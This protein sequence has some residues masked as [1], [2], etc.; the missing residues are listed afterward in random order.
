M[1]LVSGGAWMVIDV[2][3]GG[4]AGGTIG[5]TFP[6]PNPPPTAPN[7]EDAASTRPRRMLLSPVFITIGC[8]GPALRLQLSQLLLVGFSELV[9][10]QIA[11]TRIDVAD[12]TTEPITIQIPVSQS[13]GHR[14]ERPFLA[15]V[16]LPLQPL[17]IEPRSIDE[18][19][20]RMP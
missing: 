1:T 11:K 19:A 20:F 5:G 10:E 9:A 17:G 6:H 13:R 4:R 15:P 7:Y 2:G 3:R 16:E 18:N 12:H 8:S 14:H